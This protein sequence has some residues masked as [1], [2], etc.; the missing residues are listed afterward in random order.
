MTTCHVV[1]RKIRQTVEDSQMLIGV[2]MHVSITNT[3]VKFHMKIPSGKEY[4][5]NVRGLL[6]AVHRSSVPKPNHIHTILQC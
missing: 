3:C 1:S 5:E 4:G 6:F 2:F